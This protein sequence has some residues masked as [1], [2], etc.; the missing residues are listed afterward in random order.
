MKHGKKKIFRLFELID[1]YNAKKF[2]NELRFVIDFRDL[3]LGFVASLCCGVFSLRLQILFIEAQISL[4]FKKRKP[5]S[6][7]S[8]LWV[9][10]D[11]FEFVS[12][13]R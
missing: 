5:V 13:G 9:L 12:E 8:L 1:Y 11:D 2:V 6:S 4:R 10:P 7:S 3:G